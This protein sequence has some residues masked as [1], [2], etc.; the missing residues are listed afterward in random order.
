MQ[1]IPE[2]LK[3][4]SFPSKQLWVDHFSTWRGLQGEELHMCEANLCTSLGSPGYSKCNAHEQQSRKEKKSRTRSSLASVTTAGMMSFNHRIVHLKA[5]LAEEK[6][7]AGS[8]KTWQQLRSL[9]A[10]G[11]GRVQRLDAKASFS[12]SQLHI[13]I[14]AKFHLIEYEAQVTSCSNERC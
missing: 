4:L 6:L 3:G 10:Q 8:S 5:L 11:G 13:L 12:F 2:R 7:Q 14:L 1:K 9:T